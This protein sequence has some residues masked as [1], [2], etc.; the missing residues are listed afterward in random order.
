MSPEE[1]NNK[2][3]SVF[4][5]ISN[6]LAGVLWFFGAVSIP[7]IWLKDNSI[8]LYLRLVMGLIILA[9]IFWVIYY[10]FFKK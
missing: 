1:N 5:F 2:P 3:K 10:V 6:V 8:P 4:G 7:P 9:G